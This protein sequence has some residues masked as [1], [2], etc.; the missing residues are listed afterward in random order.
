M[1]N[2]IKNTLKF[3]K[4]IQIK[5]DD[6]L[7]IAS[8]TYPHNKEFKRL[9]EYRNERIMKAF[10]TERE[11]PECKSLT[12][13][14]TVRETPDNEL[15]AN[16]EGNVGGSGNENELEANLDRNVGEDMGNSVDEGKETNLDEVLKEDQEKQ[17]CPVATVQEGRGRVSVIEPINAVPIRYAEPT[18][19]ACD[20]QKEKGYVNYQKLY[21]LY[22]LKERDIIFKTSNM[23]VQRVAF[24]RSKANHF[25]LIVYNL[26]T[27]EVGIID[28]KKEESQ[29]IVRRHGE[30]P[31]RL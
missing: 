16:L 22:T 2:S 19:D 7:E 28:N 6:M 3:T 15:E 31:K 10:K 5:V 8:I 25:Y 24:E 4:S 30:I 14:E 21:V 26:K 13:L 29:D 1:V 11:Q 20:K 17:I 12:E 9:V 23:K 27:L 18:K